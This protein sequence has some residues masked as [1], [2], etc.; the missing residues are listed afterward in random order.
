MTGGA[1]YG[2]GILEW[3]SAK[4]YREQIRNNGYHAIGPVW[5][6]N[7][8]WLIIAVV[9]MFVGFP[10]IYSLVAIYLHIPLV[11]MLVG[12]IARGT[13]FSFRNYDAVKDESQRLYSRIYIHSSFI[14]PLFLGIIA[15]SA[16]SGQINPHAN[17]FLDAYIYDWFNF[18]SVAV[19]LFTVFLCGFIAAVY[20]SGQ[21]QETSEKAVYIQKT[22]LMTILG[23]ISLIFVFSA[24]RYQH[25][26]LIAWLLGSIIS[27]TATLG[28]LIFFSLTWISLKRK[29]QITVRLLLAVTIGLLWIAVTYGH[30]PNIIILKSGSTLSLLDSNVPK[31]TIIA[32]GTALL[33]GSI[34][35]LPSLFYLLYS[36]NKKDPGDYVNDQSPL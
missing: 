14:T 3:F 8:M 29:G 30:F 21:V 1:D 33:V 23:T 34:F 22:R 15:G 25:I 17:N 26:P 6:A 7:H 16:V 18:F 31:G 5:E 32:L 2:A 11:L 19:G 28:A 24:A 13:A 36:F 9:I 4:K 10:Q 12:I 20:L 27:F 35:I